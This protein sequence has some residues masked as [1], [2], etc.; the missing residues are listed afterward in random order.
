[1]QMPFRYHSYKRWIPSSISTLWCQPK[2]C[3]LLTSVSLRSVPSGFDASQRSSP[4]KP[5]SFLIFSATSR[6][7]SSLPVPTLMWQLRI[8]VMPSAFFTESSYVC[9]KSTFSNT[10]TLASA[11]SSLHRNS[12]SGFPVPQRVTASAAMP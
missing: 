12:R 3:S 8:S 1:M 6:M 9:L 5:I 11:I 10:C 4:L 7:D 2:L